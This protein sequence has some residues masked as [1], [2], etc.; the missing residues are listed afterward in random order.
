MLIRKVIPENLDKQRIDYILKEL[1]LVESRNQALALIIS[2]KVFVDNEKIVKPGKII[3][4]NKVIELKKDK[5]QW[6]SRGGIKLSHA[7][8]K[9]D[10]NVS[11]KISLDVGCSTGG[12]TDVLIKMGVKK[13]YAVDVG[14]GQLDWRLR[15]SEK[16]ILYER[17]NARELD[18]NIIPQL[19]DLV[20]CDVSFISLT[21]VLLPLKELLNNKFEILALIKPQF[22]ARKN[23]VGRGG[24]IKDSKVHK[25]ICDELT[26]WFRQNFKHKSV[27]IIDSP[28][29]GQKGNKEFFIYIKN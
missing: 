12:F 6:V 16:V 18:T 19:L 5:N 14:Y 22:E 24:I 2:G 28:I 27:N 1:E 9:F 7:L 29:T 4:C 13:V 17:T 3:K 10:I 15:N 21:K 11:E 25:R 8:K 26:I 20:V 23:E